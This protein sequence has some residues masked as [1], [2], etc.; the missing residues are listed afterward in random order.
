M[1]NWTRVNGMMGL[2]DEKRNR[3]YNRPLGGAERRHKPG[4]IL[5]SSWSK[6]TFGAS[7]GRMVSVAG[8]YGRR[9]C[10]G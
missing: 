3:E 6:A 10:V 2:E 1:G 9:T 4:I 7:Q 8:A 5:L